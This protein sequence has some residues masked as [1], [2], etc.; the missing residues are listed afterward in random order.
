MNKVAIVTVNFNTEKDTLAL[1][2]SIKKIKKNS[3]I[4][5]VIIVDNGSKNK[6]VFP[7]DFKGKI[8]LIRSEKNLGFSGGF[9]IGIKKALRQDVDYVLIV[10]NDTLIFAEMIENLLKVLKENPKIGIVTP[11]I[12][13]AKGHEFHKARYKEQELGKVFWYAG[14]YMDWANIASV[15]RG[16]DEVD[17]GQYDSIEKTEFA[18]GCCMLIKK[19]VFE[20][21]GMFNEKYFLYYEDADFTRRVEKAGFDIYYVPSAI[22]VH[23]NAAST[24]GSGSV[25][26]DYY[27]TRNRLLFGMRYAPLRSKIALIKESIRLLR[28]GRDW[29]KKGIID[30]Y[31]GRFGKGSYK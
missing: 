5:E 11:K 26:Q 16:V 17:K 8:I 4:L 13:F 22:L 25:L 18:S 1:L 7:Q 12:Y 19:E 2:S 6:L 23:V 20:K 28:S 15:H 10:N 24:G 30:F 29:Q 21:V 27:I 9:N 3:F 31:I 14:G